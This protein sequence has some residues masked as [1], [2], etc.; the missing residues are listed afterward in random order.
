MNVFFYLK[1]CT[2]FC[3]TE[4]LSSDEDEIDE[5]SQ[6]Y[7]EKLQDKVNR[8]SFQQGFGVNASIKEAIETR[9]DDDADEDDSEFEAN[10]ETALESYYTPL[11]S[12]ETNQD[13]YV[14]FKEIM[15]SELIFLNK[16]QSTV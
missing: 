8:S 1:K 14:V 7:L 4:V 2:I 15:Q 9:S 12:D 11:D 16:L 5:A 3:D 6:E 13:E 10:E